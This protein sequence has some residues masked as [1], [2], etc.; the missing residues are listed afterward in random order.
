MSTYTKNIIMAEIQKFDEWMFKIRN[1]YY[2]DHERMAHA[3]DK[4]LELA[5]E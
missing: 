3:Y 2:F 1:K 5:N 4:I